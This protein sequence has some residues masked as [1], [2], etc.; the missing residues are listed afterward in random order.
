MPDEDIIVIGAGIAGLAAARSLT[1]AG[2]AP[3]VLEGRDRIGGRIW[4]DRSLGMPLDLGASW[5]HGISRNPLMDLVRDHGI[6]TRRTFL[7]ALALYDADGR[8]LDEEEMNR[9]DA[10][11]EEISAALLELKQAADSDRPLAAAIADILALRD[12]DD[13]QKQSINWHLFSEIELEHGAD[14]ADLSLRAFDEDDF[15]R[16]PDVVFPAGYVQ[17]VDHL[18]S[19]LHI[20]LGHSVHQINYGAQGVEV[21]TAQGLFTADRAVVTLP[22]GVLQSGDV[23]FSPALPAAKLDAIQ[24]LQMGTANKIALHFS[25]RFWPEWPHYMG[26]LSET[27][28]TAMEF[29]NMDMYIGQPVLF[30]LTRGAHARALEQLAEEEMVERAMADLRHIFG[31]DLADPLASVSTRW[32]ADPFARGA[33]SHV[34]PGATMGDYDLIA[35]PVENRLFFAGEATNRQYPATVHGALL[36]GRREAEIIV[37]LATA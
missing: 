17:I 2:F 19:G 4:T 23:Q 5:I 21:A 7:G 35:A 11:G 18:A 13:S 26:Q 12:L 29:W 37:G 20:K 22:L 8:L 36:S 3:T 33:Y 32:H 16:G 24:R 31:N 27:T 28:G 1:E 25:E 15:F 6:K 14:L 10:L 9:I 30:A 34:P